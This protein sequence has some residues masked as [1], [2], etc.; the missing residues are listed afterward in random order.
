MG[1]VSVLDYLDIDTDPLV[2]Q[3][4]SL[5]IHAPF[6]LKPLVDDWTHA[7]SDS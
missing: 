7:S 3:Y 1:A 2:S 5:M 6:G 4:E